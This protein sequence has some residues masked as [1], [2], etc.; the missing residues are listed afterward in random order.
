MRYF[1]DFRPGES[2]EGGTYTLSRDE[3]TEFAKKYDPQ[4]FHLDDAASHF[5]SVVASGW[6]IA[7]IS[8]RLLVDHLVADAATLGSPG[9]DEIRW[10]K[11]VRAGDTLALRIEVSD[12]TPSKS[13][14]DRGTV[15][16]TLTLTNQ[17]GEPVMTKKAIGIFRKRP[18]SAPNE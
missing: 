2:F 3:L 10:V 1:E 16:L 12:V 13:R 4:P 9:V 7:A 5:G 17:D 8:H 15:R 6:Q 18:P 14:S 11:P